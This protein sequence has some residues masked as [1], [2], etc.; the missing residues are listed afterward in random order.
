MK[1]DKFKNNDGIRYKFEKCPI[2]EFAKVHGYLNIMPA[3]CNGDY[4][5]ME[6]INATLI[7]KHTCA[8]GDF[9]DYWIVGDK[10]KE[11]KEHPIKKDERGFLYND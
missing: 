7:R 1:V 3:F 6:C 9:C 2:A 5:A 11:A 8:N 4:P 10:S